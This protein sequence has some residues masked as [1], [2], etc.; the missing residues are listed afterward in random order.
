MEVWRTTGCRHFLRGPSGTTGSSSTRTRTRIYLADWDDI[1]AE[2]VL[3]VVGV[4]VHVVAD[5]LLAVQILYG[6]HGLEELHQLLGVRLSGEV[7]VQTL[8]VGFDS[9]TVLKKIQTLVFRTFFAHLAF[10]LMRMRIQ[11]VF[12]NDSCLASSIVK[13]LEIITLG[14]K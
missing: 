2:G 8:V 3:V 10:P 13:N 9:H 14:I 12:R 1:D 5:E 11:I 4:A 6:D 7:E